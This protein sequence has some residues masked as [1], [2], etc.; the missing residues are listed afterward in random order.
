MVNLRKEVFL[1][2]RKGANKMP[3][4]KGSCGCYNKHDAR[5]IGLIP[6]IVWNDILD[7]SEHLDTNP[8]W[9]DQKDAADR[10]GIPERSMYR[11]VEKLMEVGRI[12]KKKGYRPGTTVTTTWITIIEDS[13]LVERKTQNGEPGTTLL[14]VPRNCDLAVPILK[15]TNTNDTNSLG[16]AKDDEEPRLKPPVLLSRL[17]IT[18]GQRK[19]PSNFVSKKERLAAIAKL[20]KEFSDDEIL[21]GAKLCSSQKEKTFENGNTWKP[22]V[23]WFTDPAKTSSVSK[24]IERAIVEEKEYDEE[25]LAL[26][27]VAVQS[28]YAKSIEEC[29][30]SW[31]DIYIEFRKSNE[32]KEFFNGRKN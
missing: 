22:D 6:A 11:A 13:D 32:Y 16:T 5:E 1:C 24:F 26:F 4:Y 2:L 17:A 20:Q 23:L 18:F 7:R 10:L 31:V 3:R 21:L 8:M 19:L 28:G 30:E 14:A 25:T 29:K 15:D 12:T 9:Y 27:E